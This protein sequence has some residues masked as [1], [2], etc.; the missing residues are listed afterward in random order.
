MNKEEIQKQKEEEQS[1]IYKHRITDD[2][3]NLDINKL[4]NTLRDINNKMKQ[5]DDCY[6]G[7]LNRKIEKIDRQRNW[8]KC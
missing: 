8:N 2:K 7:D 6:W 4:A 3:G 5:M 1:L